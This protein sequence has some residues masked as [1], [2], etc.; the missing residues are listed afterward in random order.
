MCLDVSSRDPV[1]ACAR[2]GRGLEE[3]TLGLRKPPPPCSPNISAS[4][5]L[6]LPSS[7][8]SKD[9]VLYHPERG[10]Q[11]VRQGWRWFQAIP[12][13]RLPLHTAPRPGPGARPQLL[14]RPTGRSASQSN[15]EHFW[16][17]VLPRSSAAVLSGSMPSQVSMTNTCR[18]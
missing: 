3:G 18:V 13:A 2:Y 15:K 5:M 16:K 4:S 9:H 1:S 12:A 6:M 10:T 11:T 17:G 14:F 8:L 7:K